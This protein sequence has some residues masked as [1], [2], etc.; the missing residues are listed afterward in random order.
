MCVVKNTLSKTSYSDF[1]HVK[2]CLI[3]STFIISIITYF[4]HCCLHSQNNNCQCVLPAP[5]RPYLIYSGKVLKDFCKVLSKKQLLYYLQ[6]E[7]REKI[8]VKI[9][10]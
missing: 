7:L 2:E 3:N 9:S 1:V 4:T 10:S 8:L 6:V 5:K